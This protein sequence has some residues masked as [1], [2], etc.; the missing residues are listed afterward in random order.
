MPLNAARA[1]E[2]AGDEN[3]AGGRYAALGCTGDVR[4]LEGAN[5]IAAQR[6]KELSARERDVLPHVLQGRSNAEIA[7]ALNIS[8]RTVESHV[9]SILSKRG[10]KSRFAL[11]RL[12]DS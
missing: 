10:V 1:L 12:V 8:E 9:R 5:S 11:V 6:G 7:G 3:A 2:V 4:R